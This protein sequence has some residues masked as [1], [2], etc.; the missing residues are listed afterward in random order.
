[1]KKILIPTDFSATASNA[2]VYAL[3]LAKSIDAEIFVLHSY[4]MPVISTTSSGQPELVQGVYETIELNNFDRYKNEVPLLRKLATDYQLEDIKL[5]FIFEEGLLLGN[6]KRIIENESISFVVMGTNGDHSLEKKLLGSNT[7]NVINNL[8]IP[9]L[10]VPSKAKFRSLQNF[11][12]ATLLNDSDKEGINDI[13]KIAERIDAQV[14]LLHVLRKENREIVPLIKK[15]KDYFNND[16]VKIYTVLNPNLEDSVFYF[17]DEHLIDVMCIVK[18][19]LNFFERLFT[20]S[21]SKQLSYHSDIPV[22][23]LPQPTEKKYL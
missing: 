3:H 10:S 16:R 12:F 8:K 4:E 6:M 13:I 18:R 20:S 21:L 17:I 5:T 11:G 1:M 15:W 7:V 14:K 22:L 2:F 19:Q 23:I 9:I